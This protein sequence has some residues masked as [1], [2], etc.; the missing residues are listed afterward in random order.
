[1]PENILL[2]PWNFQMVRSYESMIK[3]G[4]AVILDPKYYLALSLPLLHMSDFMKIASSPEE[5]EKDIK[6]AYK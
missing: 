1:M 6:R 2:I 3:E 5:I 4:K